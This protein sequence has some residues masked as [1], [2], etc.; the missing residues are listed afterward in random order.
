[1]E[2]K[3]EKQCEIDDNKGEKLDGI[4]GTMDEE[5]NYIDDED[6]AYDPTKALILRRYELNAEIGTDWPQIRSIIEDTKNGQFDFLEFCDMAQS[7]F[8]YMHWLDD[9]VG[10]TVRTKEDVHNAV[11]LREFADLQVDDS[12]EIKAAKLIAE[13]LCMQLCTHIIPPSEGDPRSKLVVID[14]KNQRFE[15]NVDLDFGEIDP[16]P[17]FS[18]ECAL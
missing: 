4:D 6:A 12:V 5:L 17:L 14:K 18:E 16:S 10:E 9:G 8:G 11:L 3:N 7:M 1:M 13:A 15:L 2:Q